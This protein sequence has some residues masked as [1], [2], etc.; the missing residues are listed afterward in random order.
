M[1]D[2]AIGFLK[3]SNKTSSTSI[4]LSANCG[5]GKSKLIFKCKSNKCALCD[6][7]S[8]VPADRIVSTST[9]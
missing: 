7:G 5:D 8:F 3:S 2:R 1:K 9:N 4:N 6:N